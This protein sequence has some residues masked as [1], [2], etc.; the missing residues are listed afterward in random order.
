MKRIIIHNNIVNR[1][2]PFICLN[3]DETNF[4]ITMNDNL[5]CKYY[6]YLKY[7][8][9]YTKSKRIDSTAK[10]ILFALGYS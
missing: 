4:L 7:Y 6:I 1:K 3:R 5:L 2:T 9:G 8:C 10:Q